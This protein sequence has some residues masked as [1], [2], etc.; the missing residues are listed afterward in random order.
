MTQQ[1]PPPTG[2]PIGWNW[3]DPLPLESRLQ[4]HQPV[5]IPTRR[6]EL[7]LSA[8]G[9]LGLLPLDIRLS[10]DVFLAIAEKLSFVSRLEPSEVQ[11]SRTSALANMPADL[12]YWG[13]WRPLWLQR[14]PCGTLEGLDRS[15]WQIFTP[16]EAGRNQ[17]STCTGDA[18]LFSERLFEAIQWNQL[19]AILGYRCWPDE[20]GRTQG[21]YLFG[22]SWV[23]P[24][25]AVKGI[26]VLNLDT[27]P[28]SLF[29]ASNQRFKL[30]EATLRQ[31]LVAERFSN[32]MC[33]KL[34][35]H[36]H[37]LQLLWRHG[38]LAQSNDIT[39]SLG[40]I[41]SFCT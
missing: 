37:L 15:C 41:C 39:E 20:S 27:V 13:C 17:V 8:V 30:L 35:N 10:M 36:Q 33:I 7:G 26:R 40:S 16:T 31:H 6:P 38:T 29:H 12:H 4:D 21:I 32:P 1:S 34:I 28:L 18:L 14:H 9:P 24:M 2:L 22:E 11:K 23:K 5:L 19:D 3:P 25:L